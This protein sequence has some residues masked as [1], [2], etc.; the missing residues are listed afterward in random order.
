MARLILCAAL[1][2]G[3]L[4]AAEPAAAQ[5]AGAAGLAIT[6]AGP[7]EA[8]A[9]EL[10]TY[11]LQVSSIGTTAFGADA[12]LVSAAQCQAPPA[13]VSTADDDTPATLDPGERRTFRCQ[14]LTSVGETSLEVTG[15]V[16]ATDVTGTTVSV[17][18]PFT[19]QLRQPATAVSPVAVV[20][21]VARLTGTVGCVAA[22]HAVAAVEPEARTP[23]GT[24]TLRF[25]RCRPRVVR[26]TFAG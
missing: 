14:V 15:A 21:G 13:L 22:R 16:S 12:V 8:V 26:P 7:P 5:T 25:S 1:A 10:L 4:G 18:A 17:A 3:L 19:T 9:G 11:E 20:S 23:A 6:T 24:L 2:A